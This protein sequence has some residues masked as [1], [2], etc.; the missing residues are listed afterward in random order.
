M[1]NN[2]QCSG[3]AVLFTYLFYVTGRAYLSQRT[4]GVGLSDPVVL[5]FT[6]YYNRNGLKCRPSAGRYWRRCRPI[7]IS[8]VHDTIS[9]TSMP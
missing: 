4:G 5:R 9:S 7:A 8:N 1:S 3:V 6:E 2:R